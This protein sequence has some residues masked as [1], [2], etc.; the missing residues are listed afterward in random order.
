MKEAR[1]KNLAGF[2]LMSV[3]QPLCYTNS[4]NRIYHLTN[5]EIQDI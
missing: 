4:A 2:S 3:S 1:D 5:E